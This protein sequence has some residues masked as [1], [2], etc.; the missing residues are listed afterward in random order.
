MNSYQKG[1]AFEYIIMRKLAK[2]G[3]RFIIR[4]AGSKGAID[5]LASN[6]LERLAIQVKKNGYLK[7]EEKM[8]LIEAAKAFMAKPLIA[9][10]KGS[11]WRMKA[12][13]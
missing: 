3:Y 6:G 8:R 7:A 4:S 12:A 2:E 10:K 13:E 11:R 1:R 5:V 9:F